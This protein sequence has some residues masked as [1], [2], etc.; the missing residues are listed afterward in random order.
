MSSVIKTVI[1]TI[2]VPGT[3]TVYLPSRLLGPGTTVASPFGLLGTLPIVL[4]AMVYLW[5]A[6]DFAMA[7]HG[8]PAPIDPP[9]ILVATGPYRV[10]RNPMYMGV[11]LILRRKRRVRVVPNPLLRPHCLVVLSP[12]RCA[13]RRTHT[14]AEIRI[15]LPGILQH[16]VQMDSPS[17][18][19]RSIA[20]IHRAV[21]RLYGLDLGKDRSRCTSALSCRSRS[22]LRI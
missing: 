15:I 10:V 19:L 18:A 12:F 4:G 20:I 2:L 9:K 13:L 8:T 17:A 21:G 7:G 1:F 6:W 14:Q 22:S 11:L 16:R 3:V 5:C